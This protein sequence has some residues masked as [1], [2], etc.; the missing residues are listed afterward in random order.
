MD[1]I[2]GLK[3]DL[4]DFIVKQNII[5]SSIGI[6]IGYYIRDFS[7]A[8]SEGIII[9]I[10]KRIQGRKGDEEVSEIIVKIFGIE[11]RFDKIIN[12]IINMIVILLL[13]FTIQVLIPKY[14][15][16]RFV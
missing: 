13:F 16:S 1:N 14:I 9:P 10:I 11:F 8:M 3:S 2:F 6:I 15:V 4:W 7:H 5:G 12:V